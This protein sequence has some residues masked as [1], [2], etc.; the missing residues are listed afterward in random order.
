MYIHN[1]AKQ[2]LHCINIKIL[3][4]CINLHP[5]SPLN[6]SKNSAIASMEHPLVVRSMTR[7]NYPTSR[8]CLHIEVGISLVYIGNLRL[9]QSAIAL[10][11]ELMPVQNPSLHLLLFG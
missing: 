5:F 7:N 8:T 4:T 10:L 9:E 1:D 3:N 11:R 6:V 2:V